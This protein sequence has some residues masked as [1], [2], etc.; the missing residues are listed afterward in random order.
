MPVS[1]I[2]HASEAESLHT[3]LETV[4]NLRT[5]KIRGKKPQREEGELSSDDD[6]AIFES[7]R[8]SLGISTES[9]PSKSRVYPSIADIQER[10]NVFIEDTSRQITSL[11]KKLDRMS[12]SLEKAN[13]ERAEMMKIIISMNEKNTLPEVSAATW[14]LG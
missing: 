7:T 2:P 11:S 6:Q 3:S 14:L 13:A 12:S 8:K 10:Q 5:K 4:K 1:D 9:D